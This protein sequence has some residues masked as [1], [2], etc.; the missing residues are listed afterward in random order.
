MGIRV[1]GETGG[2]QRSLDVGTDTLCDRN[3]LCDAVGLD[4]A[5]TLPADCWYC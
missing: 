1:L 3:L 4:E 5:R 2:E